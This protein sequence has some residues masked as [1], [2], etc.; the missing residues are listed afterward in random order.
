MSRTEEIRP[1]DKLQELQHLVKGP[2]I[3]THLS[4]EEGYDY[5][6]KGNVC[7]EVQN[8]G[9]GD[10]LFLDIE[11][12]FTLSFGEWD[13]RYAATEEDYR[14]LCEDLEFLLDKKLYT[15][16]VYVKE[17]WICSLTVRET[18]IRKNQLLDHV[19]DFL[20]SAGCDTFIDLMQKE[21]ASIRCTFWGEKTRKIHLTGR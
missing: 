5:L 17:D 3:T 15:V 16:V 7:I 19:R 21:G 13:S 14:L 9:K 4:D 2:E 6:E 12:Q 20:H 1:M 8:P 10:N 18:E 11:D